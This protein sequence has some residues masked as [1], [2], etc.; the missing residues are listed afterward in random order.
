MESR[1][2]CY[3]WW[4]NNNNIEKMRR[5][6]KFNW[7]LNLGDEKMS[8]AKY[9]CS[10]GTWKNSKTKVEHQQV[11]AYGIG[12][13]PNIMLKILF[14]WSCWLNRSGWTSFTNYEA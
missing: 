9:R 6:Y 2:V 8:I 1:Q 12:D 3:W 14:E 11:G 7:K 4:N 5:T 13:W 10:N